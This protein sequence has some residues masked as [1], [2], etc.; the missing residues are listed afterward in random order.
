MQEP[1]SGIPA[2]GPGEVKEQ[3]VLV[4]ESVIEI[5]GMLIKRLNQT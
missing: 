2:S 5:T 4:N 1:S 3:V